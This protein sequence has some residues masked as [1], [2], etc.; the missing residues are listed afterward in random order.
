MDNNPKVLAITPGVDPFLALPEHSP[1]LVGGSLTFDEAS[2][3]TKIAVHSGATA[4]A[5]FGC[6][7]LLG[8]GSPQTFIRRD[9]LDS[10]LSVGE[11]SVTCERKCAPRSRGGFGQSA[12]LQTSTSV[13]LNVQFFRDDGH[14][15]SCSM[16]RCGTPFGDAACGAAGPRQWDAF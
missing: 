12:H 14:T 8:T 7:A 9:V 6:V 11:A 1:Y 4:L 2:F 15:C 16:S 10:M 13:R 5:P 3:T